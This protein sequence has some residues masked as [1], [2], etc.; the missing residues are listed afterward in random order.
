[1]TLAQTDIT[2]GVRELVLAIGAPSTV[3]ILTAIIAIMVI[4]R[5]NTKTS[6]RTIVLESESTAQKVVNR[7]FV[8]TQS[9]VN[10][11]VNTTIELQG[12]LSDVL[13]EAKI[14]DYK[15]ASLEETIKER[16]A[17]I[18]ERDATIK[19]RDLTIDKLS[20]HIEILEAEREQLIKQ[21]DLLNARIDTLTTRITELSMKLDV[22]I[23][24]D[25]LAKTTPPQ[26]DVAKVDPNLVTP[27][28]T[29]AD[30][31]TDNENEDIEDKI[32]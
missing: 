7:T 22:K 10:D 27:A 3:V 12:K 13:A 19:E 14:R 17:T 32:A 15:L 11:L 29:S 5:E 21:R 25:E 16:N 24:T 23:E 26:I 8:N 6:N 1:M 2:F 4:R 9:Q 20:N 30:N 28:D 31:N 18:E